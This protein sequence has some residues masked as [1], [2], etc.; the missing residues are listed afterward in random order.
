MAYFGWRMYWGCSRRNNASGCKCCPTKKATDGLVVAMIGGAVSGG[1]SA[2]GASAIA[3][4]AA[5][6]AISMA[7]NAANQ[8]MQNNGLYDFDIADMLVDGA[9]G[10]K[11]LTNLGVRTVVRP[12]RAGTSKGARAGISEAGKAARWYLKSTKNYYKDVLKGVKSDFVQAA[13]IAYASSNRMKNC[14]LH[15]VATLY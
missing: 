4:S 5:N 11:S 3:L 14:Y 9:I 2:T 1:L 8:I 15:I 12:I 6:A 7:Q 13:I 10:S